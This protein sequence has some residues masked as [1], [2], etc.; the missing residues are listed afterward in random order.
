M[1]LKEKLRDRLNQL[2]LYDFVKIQVHQGNRFGVG[3]GDTA[4]KYINIKYF[5][6]VPDKKIDPILW[7]VRAVTRKRRAELTHR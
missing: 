1:F 7:S 3:M 5:I 6:S 4:R 2:E